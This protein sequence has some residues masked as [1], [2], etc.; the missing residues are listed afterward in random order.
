MESY[1]LWLTRSD[2]SLFDR[3][4][5][6]SIRSEYQERRLEEGATQNIQEMNRRR[7][8]TDITCFLVLPDC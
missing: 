8:L 1:W 6:H 2:L 4:L 3:K 5:I 7:V